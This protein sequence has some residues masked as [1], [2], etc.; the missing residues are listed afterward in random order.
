MIQ[1]KIVS[2]PLCAEQNNI[3]IIQCLSDVDSLIHDSAIKQY[4]I[5]QLDELK[6]NFVIVNHYNFL[7]IIVLIKENAN[8]SKYLELF[9]ITGYKIL[10]KLKE[11]NAG[12]VNII[13]AEKSGYKAIAIAEGIMLGA[14]EFNKYK[15]K[16]DEKG[17]S[18]KEINIT[19]DDLTIKDETRLNALVSSVYH[20]RDL[21]NE[22]LNK[23]NAEAFAAY[24]QNMVAEKGVKTEILNLKKIES[25]KMG[26]I[27]AVNKGSVDPPTFTIMEWKPEDAKNANPIILVGKGV[28]YDTGGSNL[29]TGSYMDNMKSDMAGAA[30]M[31]NV[32][33][34][35]AETKLPLYVMALLPATDNRIGSKSIVPGD[36]I[37]MF[38]GTT[39]EIGNTDAEG[40]L[41]LADALAYA[42]KYDPILVITAATLTGSAVR[43]IGTLGIAAMENKAEQYASILNLAGEETYERTAF[44]PFWEEYSDLIK[45]KVADLINVGPAEAGAITAGKFL[46]HFTDYPFIHLDIAGPAFLDKADNYRPAG[47]SGTGIRLLYNFLEKLRNSL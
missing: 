45:S 7:L 3:H 24:C 14:Y 32:M 20:C 43:A 44:L 8:K 26:G 42:K 1:A 18:L 33:N 36:I 47:G 2:V 13:T 37:T 29:K 31:A 30:T 9:R 41:I 16:P 11:H 6:Q 40:R 17:V 23:L 19:G 22:P 38:D 25:L 10:K 5:Q 34:A 39:V 15:K 21:V 46:Q 27:L 35:I 28:T 12:C 4:V